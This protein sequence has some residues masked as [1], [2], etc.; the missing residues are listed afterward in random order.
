MTTIN[1]TFSLNKRQ[2]YPSLFVIV[3]HCF[4]LLIE[5]I[6][7][8]I[9]DFVIIDYIIVISVVIISIKI[10]TIATIATIIMVHIMK[11]AYDFHK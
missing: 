8:V 2:C 1:Y 9:V 5:A 4:Q 3:N 7:V 6:I 11:V 10:I